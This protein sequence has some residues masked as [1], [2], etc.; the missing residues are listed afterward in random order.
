M[1]HRSYIW[2]RRGISVVGVAA[3]LLVASTHGASTVPMTLN[4]MILLNNTGQAGWGGFEDFTYDG[5]AISAG[6]IGQYNA[7]VYDSELSDGGELLNGSGA[8]WNNLVNNQAPFNQDTAFPVLDITAADYPIFDRAG[9]GTNF[10]PDLYKLEVV[11]KPLPTNEAPIFNITLD[12]YDG[13]KIEDRIVGGAPYP[14]NF[15]KGKRYAEQQQWGFGYGDITGNGTTGTGMDQ[16][17]LTIEEYYDANPHDSDGFVT[18]SGALTDGLGAVE[19]L[20]AIHGSLVPVCR[21]RD[22]LS[23]RKR[24]PGRYV[25]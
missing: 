6:A 2:L 4:G 1:V 3:A 9:Y 5:S 22:Q 17:G 23:G 21:R 13:F 10:N 12:T 16:R 15:G 24:D 14:V 8:G 18:I 25:A 11:Y 20:V 7:F 19:R